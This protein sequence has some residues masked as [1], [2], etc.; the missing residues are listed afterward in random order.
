M[1]LTEVSS[2]TQA[3]KQVLCSIVEL[4]ENLT[5]KVDA[6]ESALVHR[7]LLANG[8]RDMYENDYRLSASNDVSAVRGA[9]AFLSSVPNVRG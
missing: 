8:E 7:T 6:L 3:E 2:M 9:I 1:G 4:I 5:V